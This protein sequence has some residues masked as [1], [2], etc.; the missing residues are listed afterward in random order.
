MTLNLI[1]LF[2]AGKVVSRKAAKFTKSRR[3]DGR[4]E[5]K[6]GT[7]PGKTENYFDRTKK[8]GIMMSEPAAPGDAGQARAPDL[9]VVVK[10]KKKWND[11]WFIAIQRP[12]C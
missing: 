1:Q 6:P 5:E 4:M 12:F 2:G 3:A 7:N 8:S 9:H 11:L 10:R